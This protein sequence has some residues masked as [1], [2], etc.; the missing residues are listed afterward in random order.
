VEYRIKQLQSLRKGVTEL[1]G[2]ILGALASDLHRPKFETFA[3]DVLGVIAEC[4]Y[5]LAN[6]RGWAKNTTMQPEISLRPG[7]F[8]HVKQP[9]GVVLICGPFNFP[10]QLTVVPLVNAISAGCAVVVKP[11]ELTPESAKVLEKLVNTYLD[12]E[13]YRVVQVGYH[14]SFDVMPCLFYIT[15]PFEVI[16][17]AIFRGVPLISEI[18]L[19]DPKGISALRYILSLSGVEAFCDILLILRYFLYISSDIILV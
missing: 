10:F 7:S 5:A 13:L 6:L 1:E 2:E 17:G 9:K 8:T 3:V 16:C 4:D 15:F 19:F 12:P 14:I 18:I 11:S